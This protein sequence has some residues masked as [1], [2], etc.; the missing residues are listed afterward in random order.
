MATQTQ[1]IHTS[2]SSQTNEP[3]QQSPK[4]EHSLVDNDCTQERQ[5]VPSVEKEYPKMHASREG[6]EDLVSN[7]S[8]AHHSSPAGSQIHRLPSSADP[9]SPILAPAD[10]EQPTGQSKPVTETVTTISAKKPH[11]IFTPTEKLFLTSIAT[12]ATFFSPLSASIYFPALTILQTHFST[13]PTLI[14]L[15]LTSYMIFQG[16]SP[17]FFGPLSDAFGR[18]PVY[19]AS[20]T[21]YCAANIGLALQDSYAALLVLRCLQSSGSSVSVAL[22][23]GT[24]ADI[25]GPEERGKYLGIVI[26]FTMMAP[27]LGPVIGGLLAKFLGWR[28]IFWFLVIASAIFLAVFAT[29]VPETARKIVGDGSLPAQ[30]WNRSLLDVMRGWGARRKEEGVESAAEKARIVEDLV[31]KRPKLKWP[32][33]F[34]TFVVFKE[35]DVAIVLWMSALFFAAFYDITASLPFLFQQMYG[36]DDLKIGLCYL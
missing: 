10:E 32:N 5:H 9:V 34:G 28:A 29:F 8:P 11:S 20:F 16:L 23:L 21:L 19:L 2:L 31:A 27:A 17:S 4:S 25:S 15:T 30:R 35:K 13:T 1:K 26:G 22:A 36:F 3:G 7:K 24:V 18:R 33:P 12:F 6:R 14:N